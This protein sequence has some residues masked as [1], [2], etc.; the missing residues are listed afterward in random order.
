M[1]QSANSENSKK[2]ACVFFDGHDNLK[3]VDLRGTSDILQTSPYAQQLDQCLVFLD[4]AHIR[5]TDLK[6]PIYYRAAVTL[7]AGL[8]K[9]RLVQACMRMRKLGK[10]QSVLFCVPPD[11]QSK[12][13]QQRGDPEIST[14][15]GVSDILNWSISETCADLERCV[16]LWEIQGRR[17]AH[18]EYLWKGYSGPTRQWAETFLEDEARDIDSLY[19]PGHRPTITCCEKHTEYDGV[20]EIARHVAKFGKLDTNSTALQEEQERE[21]SPEMERERQIEKPK[22][23]TP[24]QHV[25]DREVVRFVRT[26]TMRDP[27]AFL[28]AFLTLG[29]TTAAAYL[30]D[31][32]EFPSNLLVTKDF[33]RT[34]KI[35]SVGDNNKLD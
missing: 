8:T 28:P 14:P 30:A 31:L 26:G 35:V 18:Q 22:S 6:L 20:Q 5:G 11:I 25:L 23:A 29:Q 19:R 17:F 34:I 13:I 9:D 16:A 15:I 21:L 7:G 10:G 27:S 24:A 3:V 2:Q 32:G 1:N 4:E 12:V 33:A